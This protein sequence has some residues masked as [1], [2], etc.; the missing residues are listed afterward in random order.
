MVYGYIRVSS[1][2]SCEIHTCAH[3]FSK[4]SMDKNFY[5]IEEALKIED[6]YVYL[7]NSY[8]IKVAPL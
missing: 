8:S 4:K 2:M 1:D 3:P 5:P 7:N 6:R